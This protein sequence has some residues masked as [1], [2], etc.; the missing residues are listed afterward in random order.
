L[1]SQKLVSSIVHGWMS[2]I[3]RLVASDTAARDRRP[4]APL[5]Q[6][7]V[8]GAVVQPDFFAKADRP[9]AFL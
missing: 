9:A 4:L 6:S 3:C 1:D 2:R 8:I 5:G 7:V